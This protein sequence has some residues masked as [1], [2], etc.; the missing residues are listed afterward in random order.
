MQSITVPSQLIMAHNSP[1]SGTAGVTPAS[2]ASDPGQ[3]FVRFC[4]YLG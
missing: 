2:V 3:A 4:Q 1:V